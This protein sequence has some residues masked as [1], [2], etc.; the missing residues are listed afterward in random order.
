MYVCMTETENSIETRR[1][2]VNGL[3][4]VGFIVLVGAGIWLAVY[5]TRYVPSMVNRVGVAAVYLG[6]VFTPEAGPFL[7]VVPT[8]ST[9]IFFGEASSS[10]A[11]NTTATTS[12]P[13]VTAPVKWMPGTPV[14]IPGS[15]KI[16]PTTI[17]YHGLADLSI[18]IESV[19]YLTSI[20]NESFVASTTIP[21]GSRIAVK[22][23]VTNIGT[24]ISGPWTMNIIV[25]SFRE[26]FT[27]NSLVPGEPT[28]FMAYIGNVTPGIN[29]TIVV[30]VDPNNT[31][32]ESNEKNNTASTT[33]TVLDN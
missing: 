10:T 31:L 9:T 20:S 18:V 14:V 12:K 22:I 4:I 15:S 33:I 30:T 6:S 19:G 24:N 11:T 23:L 5:S 3:A 27:L 25:P 8:A 2:V 28:R 26:P 32:A 16:V 29:R 13:V 21:S 17:S 7:S 1:A